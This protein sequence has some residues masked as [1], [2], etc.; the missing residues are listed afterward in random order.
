MRSAVSLL[1][2]VLRTGLKPRNASAEDIV[3]NTAVNRIV[4][5]SMPGSSQWRPGRKAKA[6][7]LLPLQKYLTAL[8]CAE[9]E[10]DG[11]V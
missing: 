5:V 4:E 9:K 2:K 10:P 1:Q 6:D 11:L 7:R 8:V 3:S